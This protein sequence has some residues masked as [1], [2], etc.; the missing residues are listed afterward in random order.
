MSS[1]IFRVSPSTD[2]RRVAFRHHFQ[3]GDGD[4]V[5]I[6]EFESEVKDINAIVVLSFGT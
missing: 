1:D 4:M 3:F 2:L 5:T 6:F